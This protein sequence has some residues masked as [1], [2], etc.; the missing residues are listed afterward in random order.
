MEFEIITYDDLNSLKSLQPEDWPDIIPSFKFYTRSPFCTPIM[1]KV[2]DQVAGIGSLISLGKTS[3]IGHMIV[4]KDYRRKGIGYQ[5]VKE[6]LVNHE[7]TS[8]ETCLL[9]ASE[10]GRP[11]YTK[12]GFHEVSEYS[13]LQRRKHWEKRKFDDHVI[14][15]QD[16]FRTMVY[17]LDRRVSGET[18]ER[19]LSDYLE[20]SLIYLK[21]GIVMACF[22][23]DLKEGL[24]IADSEE[25]GLSLMEI[26]YSKVDKA[27]LPMNNQTGIRFLQQ[28][29]FVRTDKKGTRMI[30]GRDIQ[31]MP[32]KIYSRI[33][34]NLG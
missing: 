10:M 34:G 32:E 21:D 5:L 25:A 2:K 11:V 27:S 29:G 14:S 24:I 18:R 12:V 8:A 20:D 6:L 7:Q 28:N 13:F 33:G 16:S 19:L 1:T 30:Y 17:E 4:H 31:W 9:I 23:P 15:F 3:W 26:K 22:V